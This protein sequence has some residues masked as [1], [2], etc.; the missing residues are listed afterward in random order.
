MN[1]RKRTKGRRIQAIDVPTTVQRTVN[2]KLVSAP[3]EHPKSG[4]TIF[5]KHLPTPAPPPTRPF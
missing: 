2:G 3:N 5:V 1:N 4:N